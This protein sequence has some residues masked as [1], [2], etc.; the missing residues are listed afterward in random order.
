[1]LALLSRTHW[2]VFPS[3]GSEM[4]KSPLH[5]FRFRF[6]VFM[7]VWHGCKVSRPLKWT[8]GASQSMLLVYSLE[9][10]TNSIPWQYAIRFRRNKGLI[11]TLF[12]VAASH[13][14]FEN[15]VSQDTVA[16]TARCSCPVS[17]VFR[18]TLVWLNGLQQRDLFPRCL[19]LGSIWQKP[20]QIHRLLGRDTLLALTIWQSAIQ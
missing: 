20:V 10:R 13:I 18:S 3:K 17:V 9:L 4:V 1:M 15:Q 8:T 11:L 19:I 16:E 12:S 14:A 7:S 5:D 6:G 2:R